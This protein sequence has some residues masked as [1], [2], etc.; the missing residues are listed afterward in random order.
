MSCHHIDFVAFHF[1]LQDDGRTAIDNSLAE[2]LDH[3][4]GVVFVD[5]Q[6]LG[7]LQTRQVQSHK[8]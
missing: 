7:D 4:P 6:F 1:A 8:I 5:I 3:R 2:S